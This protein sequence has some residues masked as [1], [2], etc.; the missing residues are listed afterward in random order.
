MSI[1]LQPLLKNN[2]ISLKPL[3]ETDFEALYAVAS[4]PLIWEQHPDKLRHTRDGF[5]KY[6]NSGIA[7][8]GAFLICDAASGDIIGC[9]RYYDHD[10]AKKQIAIGWTFLAKKYWGGVYNTALKTLMID[11]AFT[12]ADTVVFDIGENNMRSRKAVEKLGGIFIKHEDDWVRYAIEKEA[13]LSRN[14]LKT[15]L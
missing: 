13:W 3:R 4:D 12:F 5:K 9:T 7:S 14:L 1:D 10:P 15:T 2:L 8:G 11:Y 6:F